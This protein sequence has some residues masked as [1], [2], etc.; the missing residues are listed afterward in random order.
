MELLWTLFPFPVDLIALHS[1][2]P[3]ELASLELLLLG[4]GKQLERRG[5]L[6]ACCTWSTWQCIAV[7]F[8]YPVFTM[9]SVLEE[10][11]YLLMKLQALPF[12]VKSV[13][14]SLSL[15]RTESSL[16]WSS[17]LVPSSS[18]SKGVPPLKW[19]EEN[20]SHTTLLVVF[21][22]FLP[23]SQEVAHQKVLWSLALAWMRNQ[24]ISFS[25]FEKNWASL[26]F[27]SRNPS[28]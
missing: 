4:Q 3:W 14:L 11:A 8:H 17:Q 22:A 21:S 1:F 23:L 24:I 25:F 16:L 10:N 18:L 5:Y 13:S 12:L 20:S 28:R 15:C 9:P 7:L 26:G 2:N 6:K 19:K 27:H